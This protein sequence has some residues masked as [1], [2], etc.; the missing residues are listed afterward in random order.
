MS[1]WARFHITADEVCR[2]LRSLHQAE[3]P[4]FVPMEASLISMTERMLELRLQSGRR[5][6]LPLRACRNNL[7]TIAFSKEALRQRG[8]LQ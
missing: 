7:G 1:R 8:L 6:A 4:A 5:L 2:R 3:A